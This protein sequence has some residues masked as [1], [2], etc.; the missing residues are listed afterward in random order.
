VSTIGQLDGEG[1]GFQEGAVFM[2]RGCIK[3]P[4]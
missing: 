1:V 4:G 3:G 2:A